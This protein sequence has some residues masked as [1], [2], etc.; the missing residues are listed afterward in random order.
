METY[1]ILFHEYRTST[2][3][4]AATFIRRGWKLSTAPIT[5]ADETVWWL[6]T[7]GLF[8]GVSANLEIALG[9]G[10]AS[11]R[12]GTKPLKGFEFVFPDVVSHG[13]VFEA[14]ISRNGDGVLRLSCSTR[15]EEDLCASDVELRIRRAFVSLMQCQQGWADKIVAIY[16]IFGNC[17]GQMAVVGDEFFGAPFLACWVVVIAVDA[18]PSVS[19][20]LI[21]DGRV[22]LLHVDFARSFVADIDGTGLRAIR[23]ITIL[24]GDFGTGLGTT[25]SGDTVLAVDA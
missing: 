3:R 10:S 21:L 8:E 15:S 14:D 22:D 4:P 9:S 17:D 2:Y 1:S 11:V 24:K 25:D 12:C 18:E 5:V 16:E 7:F 23:P 13:R 6:E 19:N 20:S